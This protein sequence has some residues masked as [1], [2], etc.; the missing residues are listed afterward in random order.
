MPTTVTSAS[1][2]R[3]RRKAMAKTTRRSSS[4]RPTS[5][6]EWKLGECHSAMKVCWMALVWVWMAA[7]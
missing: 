1:Q 5:P 2:S 7:R 4:S 3:G 6:R